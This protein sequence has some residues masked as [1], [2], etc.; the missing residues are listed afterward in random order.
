MASEQYSTLLAAIQ[1]VPDPRKA[2]GKRYSWAVLL[3]LLVAGL[4]SNYQTARAIAQWVQLHFTTW[5]AAIPDLTRPP[6]ES[7]LRRALRLLDVQM[8]EQHIAQFVATLPAPAG[9]Q[10][11]VISAQGEILQGQALDGKTV[12]TAT[13]HGNRTHLVSRVAHGSGRTVA[14]IAVAEKSVEVAAS[15]TLLREQELSGVVLTMDA[16]LTHRGLAAHIRQQRGHYLMIVKKN[17]PQM[18]EELA[19]FFSLPGIL[20][21][22]EHYDRWRTMD[23]AHGRLEIR[24]LECLSGSCSDWRWP[25]V[26]QVIRR[27]CE[28]QVRRKGRLK[29]SVEISYALCSLTAAEVGAA[30]LEQ[31]W[32]G[33]WT[34]ENCK[35]YVRDVTLGEDRHPMYRG[36]APQALAAIRNGLIDLWRAQGWRYIADAVR[37][38]A[39]SLHDTLTLIGADPERL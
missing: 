31:L 25:D 10:G 15:Q 20:A 32:R 23:K 6:S 38:C 5:H 34:I 17:H 36:T 37:A 7:T 28:R 14:Q 33:H 26:A 30:G 13:A 24:T 8:L 11:C 4:A 21:D 22:D 35:H 18:Y 1:A 29:R 19:T 3:T 39:A 16:G 12:R 27:T 9:Y 2:R